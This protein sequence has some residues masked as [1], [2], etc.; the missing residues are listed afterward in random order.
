MKIIY[1]IRLL[2]LICLVMSIGI[3]TSCNKKEDP[4]SGNVEL[5]S[6]GP[7]GVK[8][9]DQI[10]F[11]GKN[12]DKVTSIKLVGVSIPSSSFVEQT[13]ELIVIVVPETAERGLVTLTAPEGNI[14]SKTV[15]D[16]EVPVTITSVTASARPEDN[17]TITGTYMNWIKEIWFTKDILV[18]DSDFVSKSLTELVVKVPLR[19][20]TGSLLFN[21]GGTD[22]LSIVSENDLEVVLPSIIGFSPIPLEHGGDLTITGTDLDLTEGILFKGLSGP[23]T[24][25]VSKSATEIVVTVPQSANRGI[26]TLVAYSGIAVASIEKLRFVGELPDLAPLGYAFYTDALQNGWGNWGWGCDRDFANTENVRDGEASIKVTYTG[27]GGLYLGGGNVAINGYTELA[28]SIFGT[29][30]TNGKQIEVKVN[31]GTAYVITIEEGVWVEYKLTMANVGNP[32][33]ITDLAFQNLADWLGT[34]YV[35]H[36]G[37][38]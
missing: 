3:V 25:F 33:Q 32:T 37:L 24:D 21:T 35:D 31:W 16:L 34:I 9:G 30:G 17:I 1:N 28:F 11:I 26:I 6:F 29:P 12:L 36:I 13:S 4:G 8:H 2:S 18:R 22:P 23:V 15:L 27:G 7:S 19:A 5:L 38:R 10:R 20:R 14:V